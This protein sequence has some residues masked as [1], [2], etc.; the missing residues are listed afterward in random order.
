MKCYKT[1][2]KEAY[3]ETI[4]KKSKFIAHVKPI[5]TEA[6]AV[7]FINKIKSKY[8][9]AT[10]NVYAYILEDNS[11][12]RYSDDGEPQ[13]TAGVPTLQAIK[14]LNLNN[15][16]VVI[17]RYFGG[18]LLGASGLIR[19]YGKSAKEGLI[20][21]QIISKKQYLRVE[22]IIE[23]T[24]L[25]KIQ[26]EVNMQG[27]FIEGTIYEDNVKMVILVPEEDIEKFKRGLEDVIH[28]KIVLNILGEKLISIDSQN[29]ILET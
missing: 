18:T 7:D 9:D 17:T 4:E 28:D 27:C 24:L 26:S 21:A 15:V 23:Y 6:E 22:I 14:S 2:L 1:V 19:A 20:E 3:N 16:V 11:I 29:K 12:Q 13:G 8:W 25:G 10:H 5:E